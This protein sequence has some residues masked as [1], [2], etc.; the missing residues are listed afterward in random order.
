MLIDIKNLPITRTVKG[1]I[2]IGAHECEERQSYV[3][4][5]NITDNEIIWIDALKHKVIEIIT[6]YPSIRIFN[7][8]I[9]DTDGETIEFKITNNYQSSSILNLKEHLNKHPDIF[10]INRIQMKTKTI[11]TFYIDNK[12]NFD[13]YNFMNLD[14]QGVEL[15][16]L[17]GAGNILNH[18][19]YI[20]LEVNLIELYEN[21]ALLSDIDEYLSKFGFKMEKCFITEHGWGDAFYVKKNN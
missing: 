19:D 12:L 20:Y 1:V 17:K 13:D 3:D 21:C 16:A 9:S 11:Q 4:N 7:E 10:E 6:M 2:H 14:I 18:I 5:F 8:C 15:L